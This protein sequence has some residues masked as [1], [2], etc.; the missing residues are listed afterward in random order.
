MLIRRRSRERESTREPGP[1]AANACVVL[2]MRS[3][4]RKRSH[5]RSAWCACQA[6]N[7]R[8]SEQQRKAEYVWYPGCLEHQ[9]PEVF[10]RAV[11]PLHL[12]HLGYAGYPEYPRHSED[13]GSSAYPGSSGIH[14][15]FEATY[16]R[17]VLLEAEEG[18]AADGVAAFP[19]GQERDEE[20]AVV[21]RRL[22]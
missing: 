8:Y 16:R 22:A 14:G 20:L 1:P 2:H 12:G 7:A 4:A 17:D 18:G 21:Q 15:I 13:S 11:Y 3:R 5:A 9:R 19:V 10:R 6:V